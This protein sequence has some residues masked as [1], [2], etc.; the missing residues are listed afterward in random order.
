MIKALCGGRWGNLFWCMVIQRHNLE[1]QGL[2]TSAKWCIWP[3]QGTAMLNICWN[4][5]LERTIHKIE[6]NEEVKVYESMSAWTQSLGVTL[7]WNTL[8]S[9]LLQTWSKNTV[10]NNLGEQKPHKLLNDTIFTHIKQTHSNKGVGNFSM[11][12]RDVEIDFMSWAYK[13]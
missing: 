2:G 8:N 3:L 7:P 11:A 6:N 4:K 12:L 5:S 13:V 9:C 1:F 10:K